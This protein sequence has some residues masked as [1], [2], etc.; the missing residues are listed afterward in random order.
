MTTPKMNTEQAIMILIRSRLGSDELE[1]RYTSNGFKPNLRKFH[2]PRSIYT[3]GPPSIWRYTV[4]TKTWRPLDDW[5]ISQKRK[6]TH[7]PAYLYKDD[8]FRPERPRCTSCKTREQMQLAGSSA[9]SKSTIQV[10]HLVLKIPKPQEK[11]K[12]HNFVGHFVREIIRK[13]STMPQTRKTQ[14]SPYSILESHCPHPPG[15]LT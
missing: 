5:P 14:E 1:S 6:S 11:L 3:A 15:L 4:S 13:T 12:C 7:S 2:P 9:L 8:V 10:M